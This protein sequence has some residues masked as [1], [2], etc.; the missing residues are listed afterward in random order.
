[1]VLVWSRYSAGTDQVC[2][3]YGAGYRAGMKQ[4]WCWYESGY[5]VGT[6]SVLISSL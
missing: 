6:V 2:N 5:E 3:R 1:M 4:V